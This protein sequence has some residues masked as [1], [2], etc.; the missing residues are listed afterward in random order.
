MTTDLPDLDPT[1]LIDWFNSQTDSTGFPG[2]TLAPDRKML[3]V[4]SRK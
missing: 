3:L 1:R 2:I 4:L